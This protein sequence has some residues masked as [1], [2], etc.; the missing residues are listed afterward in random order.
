MSASPD[1]SV[2][3]FLGPHAG[4]SRALPSHLLSKEK[5]FYARNFLFREGECFRSPLMTTDGMPLGVLPGD[6]TDI[7]LITPFYSS[8]NDSLLMTFSGK[9]GYLLNFLGSPLQLGFDSPIN[10]DLNNEYRWQGLVNRGRVYVCSPLAGVLEYD[11]TTPATLR[12]AITT[13]TA[14]SAKYIENFHDHL[15]IANLLVDA[16]SHVL[17]VAYSDIGKF[18]DFL[19]TDVNEADFFDLEASNFNLAAGLGITGLKR[20]GNV[21]AIY[22]ADSIWLMRYVGFDNG[23]MEFEEY[24]QGVGAWLPYSVIGTANY[25]L[26]IGRDNIYRF[27]GASIQPIGDEIRKWFYENLTSD[28]TRRNR[29]WGHINVPR[30][31]ITWYF[32]SRDNETDEVDAG[33]VWN[34]RENHWTTIDG[35]GRTAVLGFPTRTYTWTD[36]LDFASATIDGLSAVAATNDELGSFVDISY[37]LY[38]VGSVLAREVLT[39]DVNPTI[40]TH[41][42][43]TLPTLETGD[44]TLQSL[45]KVKEI[46]YINIHSLMKGKLIFVATAQPRIVVSASVRD[47]LP[48]EYFNPTTEQPDLLT[49]NQIGIFQNAI[50]NVGFQTLAPDTEQRLDS[51]KNEADFTYSGPDTLTRGRGLGVNLHGRVFRLRFVFHDCLNITWKGHTL[52]IYN[53]QNAEN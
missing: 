8:N 9:G 28:P 13:G 15:V 2:V 38:A 40:L 14:Y 32:I 47:S 3:E 49:F 44:I 41:P 16:E 35:S 29:T 18:Y 48:Y 23:V 1:H 31:T 39:S 51:L 34:Y 4:M 5:F 46:S 17:R 22:T 6:D 26:F 10:E 36:L 25:H 42:T 50:N 37:D 12:R 27:D 7:T 43:D 52:E 21:C 53:V 45:D 20:I 30:Q 19:P 11:G 33:I 24:V